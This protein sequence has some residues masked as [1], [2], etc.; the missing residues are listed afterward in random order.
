MTLEL[1]PADIYKTSVLSRSRIS[2]LATFGS[3]YKT[4]SFT[5]RR[6]VHLAYSKAHINSP[7]RGNNV[8]VADIDLGAAEVGPKGMV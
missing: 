4:H 1:K 8:V 6:L 7:T 2:S 3:R 5:L